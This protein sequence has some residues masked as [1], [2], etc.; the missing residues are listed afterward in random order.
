[1][2]PST[3][4]RTTAAQLQAELQALEAAGEKAKAERAKLASQKAAVEGQVRGLGDQI[5]DATLKAT[6]ATLKEENAARA[7][8]LERLRGAQAGAGAG[9][10][11]AAPLL[12]KKALEKLQKDYKRCGLAACVRA[13]CDPW[14]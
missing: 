10:G 4:Q 8:K 6:L 9:A 14:A 3:T 2:P 7:A 11:G 5:D 13:S 1:M 12:D